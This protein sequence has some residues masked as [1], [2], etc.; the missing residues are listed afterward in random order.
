MTPDTTVTDPE[1][2]RYQEGQ[3]LITRFGEA[4]KI[5]IAASKLR[6][7][8]PNDRESLSELLDELPAK[9]HNHRIS[10]NAI[11]VSDQRVASF[12]HIQEPLPDETEILTGY[13]IALTNPDH[14]FPSIIV[15]C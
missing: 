14:H 9:M 2:W 10:M 1:L 4:I 15:L 6:A 3:Q 11:T 8:Y 5:A 12:H 13:S 7:L